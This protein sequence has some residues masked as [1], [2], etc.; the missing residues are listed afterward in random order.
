MF[1]Y[2]TVFDPTRSH[3]EDDLHQQL[4]LYHSFEGS[5]NSLN[6]KLGQIGVIQGLWSLTTTLSEDPEVKEK[7]VELEK[8]ILLVIHVES[9][10]FISLGLA[11]DGSTPYQFYLSHLWLCYR[12]FTLWHGNFSSFEDARELTNLLNEYFVPFWIDLQATPGAIV[13]KGVASLWPEHHRVAELDFSPSDQSWESLINQDILL[14]SESYLGIKDILV[15][16]LPPYGRG[17]G[18]KTQG[19]VRHFSSDLDITSHISNWLYHSHAVYDTLSSHVLASNTHYKETPAEA[20]GE[21]AANTTG[22]TILHNLTLPI[23]LAYDA[24]QEVGATTGISSSIS[25]FM[26]YFPKWTTSPMSAMVANDTITESL[27]TA[28]PYGYLISPLCGRSLPDN[29]KMRIVHSQM[30]TPN[31]KTYNCLFWYYRDVVVV[32]VSEPT[33]EK[34][35]DRQYLEDLSYKLFRSIERFYA[36]AFQADAHSKKDPFG[37][38]LLSKHSGELRC[39][40]PSCPNMGDKIYSTFLDQLPQDKLWE[41]QLELV[42]FLQSLQNSRRLHEASEERLLRLSNGV[43]CFLRETPDELALVVANWF[44]ETSQKGS[45]LISGLG[46]A[47]TRWWLNRT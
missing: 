44:D 17:P 30:G 29:Y 20:N 22:E 39:S 13:R 18:N 21:V 26:D 43:V 19:L 35:W 12:F 33:F 37:Y 10:F 47:A 36:T 16:H 38:A 6:D 9:R 42:Q 31:E 23:T 1:Q 24:V 25:L 34:I 27:A 46:P 45:T 41:L 11:H 7:V 14:E 2:I 5:E 28:P 4:L 15:Y 32:I 3:G 40:I 8:N